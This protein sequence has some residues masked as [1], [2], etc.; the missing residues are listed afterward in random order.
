MSST[1]EDLLLHAGRM[2]SACYGPRAPCKQTL[3]LILSPVLWD[4]LTCSILKSLARASFCR[5]GVE[6]R[7]EP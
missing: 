3:L 7:A 1:T 4:A 6:H 5:A 2:K